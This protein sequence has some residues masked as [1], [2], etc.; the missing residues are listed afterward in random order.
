MNKKIIIGIIIL[1]VILFVLLFSGG[2][3]RP[4]EEELSLEDLKN[5]A[6][7]WIENNAPTFVFDGENL[8]FIDYQKTEE[9]RY[10]MIFSFQSRQAGYGDRIDQM[11]AQVITDHEI[12]IVLE[13]GQVIGAVTDGAYDEIA[14]EMIEET[15]PETMEIELYFVMV[16]EGQEQLVTVPRSIPYTRAVAR[17][18][19]EELLGGPI[20]GGILTAIP[21]GVELKNITIE[22][23]VATA[24]FDEKLQEGVA[25]SARVT[26]IR[27]QIERTLL[28]FDTVQE[29]IITI[30][31]QSE[32]ILQP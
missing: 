29:V 16:I 6:G 12:E 7:D 22:G 28:Q 11:P 24:D 17:A 8:S 32:E 23:G 15:W 9:G 26:M 4:P 1:V 18:A 30:N 13:N 31:G 2:K 20:T 10:E 21:E 5:I 19:L 3:D 14:G 25:G 27:Q